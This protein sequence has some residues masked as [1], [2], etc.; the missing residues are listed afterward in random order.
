MEFICNKLT[1]LVSSLKKKP[2]NA[3]E[4]KRPEFDNDFKEFKTQIGALHV[5]NYLIR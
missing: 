3:L 2:Y 1:V 5:C 4:Q